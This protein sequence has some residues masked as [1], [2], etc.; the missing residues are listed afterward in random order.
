MDSITE[1]KDF[2]ELHFGMDEGLFSGTG[3][4][5]QGTVRKCQRQYFSKLFWNILLNVGGGASFGHNLSGLYGRTAN[6]HSDYL[7]LQRSFLKEDRLTVSLW[8]VCPFERHRA[9]TQYTTQG[10]YTGFTHTINVSRQF[11]VKLSL[12]FGNNKIEVK[13]TSKNLDNKDVVGGLKAPKE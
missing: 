12:K 9:Q 8:T 6:Y 10:E 2:R 3:I 11:G 7:S 4:I 13:K 5:Q 1:D